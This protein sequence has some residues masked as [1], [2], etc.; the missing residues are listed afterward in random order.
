MEH[1]KHKHK[2]RSIAATCPA[3][4]EMN[5]ETML[6]GQSAKETR[7]RDA[8]TFQPTS[9]QKKNSMFRVRVGGFRR[10][11][12]TKPPLWLPLPCGRDLVHLCETRPNRAPPPTN[13][14]TTR[15]HIP[16]PSSIPSGA[17]KKPEVADAIVTSMCVQP[18]QG[19]AMRSLSSGFLPHC[20]FVLLGGVP[21]SGATC[22]SFSAW[23]PICKASSVTHC[24]S[25]G[26][27]WTLSKNWKRNVAVRQH[28][29]LLKCLSI[30]ANL[31]ATSIAPMSTALA[32]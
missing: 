24:G 30:T 26:L 2:F 19:S 31:N 22:P 28:I 32:W 3:E 10:V 17:E 23:L 16:A 13:Q 20:F 15:R 18:H 5:S 21:D 1:N 4:H 12:K 7:G 9:H 27:N 6:V 8:S 29:R 14:Q 25:S 11:S